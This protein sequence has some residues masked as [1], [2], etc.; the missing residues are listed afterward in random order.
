MNT[1]TLLFKNTIKIILLG[2][3]L[4]LFQGV[5]AQEKEQGEVVKDT[6]KFRVADKVANKEISVQNNPF[7]PLMGF[8]PLKNN[9][10]GSN[11][12]RIAVMFDGNNA[13]PY[14]KPEIFVERNKPKLAP[15][16]VNYVP[17][18]IDLNFIPKNDTIIGYWDKLAK[19]GF[20]MNQ[21]SFVNWSSGGDNSISG[22]VKVDLGLKFTKGRLIWDT[23][24]AVRYG[25]NKQ[26]GREM[27][28]TDDVLELNS[29]FGYKS[30]I[31]SDWYYTSKL[32]YKTQFTEGYAYPNIEQPISMFM[33][34][35]YLFLGVGAEYSEPMTNM[36]FYIA[37][38]TLK[39]TFVM[40]ETLANQG[41]FGVDEAVYDENGVLI[42]KG[43]NSRSEVGLLLSNEWKR[44]IFKNITIDHK[45]TLYTD[46]VNGFGNVDVSWQI[47]FD[48]KINNFVRANV[49]A[50]LIYDDNILNKR[51][52][53]GEQII[54]GPRVQFKQLLGVGLAYTF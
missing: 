21:I 22:L 24:L 19:V 42:R 3:S 2:M 12:T 38:I 31:L 49:G 34:P 13:I 54:E 20:D 32:N 52:V 39:S 37:P 9:S 11:R 44:E 28:K 27:R 46:Y 10:V 30:G 50:Q 23:N 47:S 7:N 1:I 16:V 41:A 53:N 51:E 14:F 4:I 8:L 43:K 29:T 18:K 40:D 48:M 25:L 6:V 35:A 33:A 45:L 26:E 17:T 15:I 5:S 36:K